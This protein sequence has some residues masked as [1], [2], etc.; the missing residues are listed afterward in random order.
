MEV[1]R[2]GQRRT[3]KQMFSGFATNMAMGGYTPVK[4]HVWLA[5]LRSRETIVPLAYPDGYAQVDFG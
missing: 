1:R 2:S 4:N 5:R 3:V